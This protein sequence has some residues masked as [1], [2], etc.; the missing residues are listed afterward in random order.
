MND[1]EQF[2]NPSFD[3]QLAFSSPVIIGPKL[4]SDDLI[5]FSTKQKQNSLENVIL[6][7]PSFPELEPHAIFNLSNSASHCSN[8]NMKCPSNNLSN[9]LSNR[10][11]LIN[12]NKESIHESSSNKQK[13]DDLDLKAATI[14]RSDNYKNSL[15]NNQSSIPL[16]QTQTNKTTLKKKIDIKKTL[17]AIFIKANPKNLID[18]F[19][20][21]VAITILV[22]FLTVF[23]LFADDIRTSAFTITADPI[24]DI[25]TITCLGIFSIEILLQT[26]VRKD[27]FLSFFFYL[28][29]ISTVSLL[30]DIQLFEQAILLKNNASTNAAQM[31]RMSRASR[32][33]TRAARIIR[34]VRLIRIVKLY[35][36]AV[37]KQEQN[38]KKKLEKKSIPNV[39]MKINKPSILLMK[40]NGAPKKLSNFNMNTKK[41][42]S[43]MTEINF[44][45]KRESVLS[46]NNGLQPRLSKFSNNSPSPLL[47]NHRLTR[48]S[49]ASEMPR[50]KSRLSHKWYMN[51]TPNNSGLQSSPL[52]SLKSPN[53]IHS[54]LGIHESLN[55][56]GTEKD[57]SLLEIQDEIK[58][59]ESVVGKK[60]SERSTKRVIIIVLLLIIIIP[61]FDS[62]FYFDPSYSFLSGVAFLSKVQDPNNGTLLISQS[63]LEAFCQSYISNEITNTLSTLI[64][65]STPF[66]NTSCF[67]FQSINPTSVRFDEK[68]A[69]EVA[70]EYDGGMINAVVDQS[71]SSYYT[72]I[73][74]MIRTIFVTVVLLTGCLL[75]S[76]DANELVLNP[77]E[78]L[79]EKV[80]KIAENPLGIKE[81]KLATE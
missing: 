72:A 28:D 20:D 75:F 26:L 4:P 52:K 15:E 67:Y 79:I 25:L 77:I 71:L 10:D 53:S 23:V 41:D 17:T 1:Q 6:S 55:P 39:N 64:S 5:F 56:E 43:V 30:F 70:L 9:N 24:F 76:R 38:M 19:L 49:N 57:N 16:T 45:K 3:P 12:S 73:I 51:N 32:I 63:D 65:L 14:S 81:F 74:N 66:Y 27:Y 33:G 31:S 54:F 18:K 11:S 21:S 37:Y 29:V 60:L 35:K 42:S 61:L 36:A 47:N 48:L 78:R 7:F 80:H 40:E 59:K 50:L 44:S 58:L 68:Y 62:T 8:L 46:P 22:N 13:N 69:V 34:L 2:L